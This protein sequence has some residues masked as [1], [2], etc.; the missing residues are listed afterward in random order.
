MGKVVF[1]NFAT[2]QV[3]GSIEESSPSG[4]NT[5]PQDE[6]FCKPEIISETDDGFLVADCGGFINFMPKHNPAMDLGCV[7]GFGFDE[8][9]E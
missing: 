2:K 9:D 1:V 8:D 5:P 3:T 7:M 6:E 4:L